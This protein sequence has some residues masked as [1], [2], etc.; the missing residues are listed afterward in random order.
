MVHSDHEPLKRKRNAHEASVPTDLIPRPMPSH[1]DTAPINYLAQNSMEKLRLIQGDRDTFTDILGLIEDYE[2][3]LSKHESLALRLGAKLTGPRLLK[4]L[5]SAFEG[6]IVTSPS[7]TP[8]NRP[9]CWVDIVTFAKENPNDFVL[10]NVMGKDR[11]CRFNLYGYGVEITE[12]DWRLIVSGAVDRLMPQ[13][14]LDQDETAELATV[15]I[16]ESRLQMLIMRA[17][18]VAKR[19]R[20][21]NYNLGRRKLAIEKRRSHQQS[22]P[23]SQQHQM[24]HSRHSSQHHHDQQQ[25]PHQVAS[26]GNRSSWYP[27]H[28]HGPSGGYD[29]HADLLQQ[30]ETQQQPKIQTYSQQMPYSQSQSQPQPPQLQLQPPSSSLVVSITDDQVPRRPTSLPVSPI[31]TPVIQLPPLT[32]ISGKGH[33]NSTSGSSSKGHSGSNSNSS[34][35]LSVGSQAYRRLTPEVTLDPGPID[36]E[37]F[38][39][40]LIMAR[41]ERLEKGA[42]V[43]PQCDRCCT[44]KHAKCAWK[45]VTEEEMALVNKDSG[46]ISS[47]NLN[48]N[49]GTSSSISSSSGGGSNQSLPGINLAVPMNHDD[50]LLSPT[51]EQLT[52]KTTSR[53]ET[54]A[55]EDSN[56]LAP[57]TPSPEHQHHRGAAPD[58]HMRMEVDNSESSAAMVTATATEV[59][60]K[61]TNTVT[62]MAMAMAIAIV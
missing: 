19:A 51:M 4:A 30:F 55:G 36:T 28:R 13:Q 2:G 7:Q 57:G 53:D 29:L 16:I 23:Q 47:A 35:R 25:Q 54:T 27:H 22:P 49:G 39:R 58:M 31:P 3:V 60:R 17:D 18:E 44:K 59:T 52:P 6:P 15:D 33:G 41:I 61:I 24:H 40:E 1:I 56:S 37:T 42:P 50:R 11:V 32:P 26:N 48:L 5:E 8:Y 62:V 38:N 21:L 14:P 45:M 43:V 34:N 46:N 9:V 10:T 12:D 20:Q